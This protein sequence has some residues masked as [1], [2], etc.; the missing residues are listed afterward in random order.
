VPLQQIRAAPY[1]AA[2]PLLRPVSK[3]M[4]DL[5]RPWEADA[6]ARLALRDDPASEWARETV[7]SLRPVLARDPPL[8]LP[9]GNPTLSADLSA[10]PLPVWPRAN[11]DPHEAARGETA[12][13]SREPAR[14]EIRFFDDAAASGLEFRF[15]NS[16]DPPGSILRMHE[17][18]G[19]GI[20]VI[21][22][23]G[24]QWP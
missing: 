1:P 19:G 23:D 7:E 13:T 11:S 16:A 15:A 17:F 9:A 10:W 4:E 2:A 12:S 14:S 24:D 22:Y 21:D 20:A 3:L 5:H 18:T 8:T 6:W